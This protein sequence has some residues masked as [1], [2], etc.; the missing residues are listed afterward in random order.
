MA[1]RGVMT[2]LQAALAGIGG[3]AGGYVQMEETKRRRQQEDEARKRQEMLDVVGL[4]ERGFMSPE[5]LAQQKAQGTKTAGS[6]LQN[7]FLSAMN[8]RA[9]VLPPPTAQDVGT[10]SEAL[11]TAGRAPQRIVTAGGTELVRSELPS[12]REERLG[13]LKEERTRMGKLE[14]R[15]Y[16]E[17]L[18]AE[19]AK[20]RDKMTPYQQAMIDLEKE[21]LRDERQKS[22]LLQSV[23]EINPIVARNAN[24]L[25]D[26]FRS[27]PT[28]KNAETI[29]QQA[30][31]VRSA[32][33][34]GDAA[35]DLSL[36][37]AYMRVL[38]PASVVREREFANAQN[39]AG[40]PDRIRNVYN[41]VL[42]GTR[43]SENQRQQ[44]V[45][46]SDRIAR[47][48]REAMKVQIDRY[49]NMATRYGVPADLVVYDPFESLFR[50]EDETRTSPP[51]A[52]AASPT[53][54]TRP[55]RP[56]E[57]I[58]EYLASTRGGR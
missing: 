29:A 2:A 3:A 21:K 43:L 5:Q 13:L 24:T 51:A 16:E 11:A 10:T 47:D 30:R 53:G 46:G 58:E 52:S 50:D 25:R 8:P 33:K 32:A 28:I 6:V 34:S 54:A 7:A 27:E 12:E 17:G 20:Q 31:I 22:K 23:S 15:R 38:D 49:G 55:R 40:V 19:Q 26:D 39:A 9:G 56:G 35:S 44:F 42:R 45:G 36:I 1:R 18:M 14:E 4:Q 48:A 41:N 57:S 37:F